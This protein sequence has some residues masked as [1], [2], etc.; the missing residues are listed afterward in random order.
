MFYTLCLPNFIKTKHV[1]GIRNP[2]NNK[3]SKHKFGV[4]SLILYVQ[5]LSVKKG[6]LGNA[7]L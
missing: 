5:Y 4:I 1:I 7:Q 2:A 3:K 6:H